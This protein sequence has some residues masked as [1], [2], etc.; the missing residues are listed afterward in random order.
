MAAFNSFQDVLPDPNNSI[1]NAGQATGSA[2]P[3]YASVELT[4]E[5][6]NMRS[7][8][9]SGRLISRSIAYHTWKVNIGYNPMTRGDFENIYNF[10]IHRRG[11]M[12]PFFVSL[13]QYRLAQ[14]ASFVVHQGTGSTPLEAA[15]TNFAGATSALIGRSGYNSGS[16]GSSSGSYIK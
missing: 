8:T 16:P 9:N 13:P 14:N 4:S 10:L 2:G 11:S 6:K 3:G 1:G 12:T 7:R 5:N 15:G